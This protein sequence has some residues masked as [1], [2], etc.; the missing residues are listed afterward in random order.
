MADAGTVVWAGRRPED[1]RPAG[2][3]G[4]LERAGAPHAAAGG[5]TVTTGTARAASP[6]SFR[7][8]A[9]GGRAGVV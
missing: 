8:P 6:A 9:V 2:P 5:G 4:K 3:W 7:R 1:P